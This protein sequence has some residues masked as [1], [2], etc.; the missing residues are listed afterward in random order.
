[1]LIL[2]SRRGG[3]A[4]LACVRR[5]LLSVPYCIISSDSVWDEGARFLCGW[6]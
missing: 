5:C 1:M 4:I 3:K 2:L 6:C